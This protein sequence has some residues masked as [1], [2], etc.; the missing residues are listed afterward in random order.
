MKQFSNV[1][2]DLTL[3]LSK[4]ILKYENLLIMG[5]FNI[6]VKS[7]NLAFDYLD[8]FCIQFDLANYIKSETCFTKNRKSFIDL[9]FTNTPLPFQKSHLSETNLSNYHKLI[10]T[11][12]KTNFSSLEFKVLSY[13]N[14]NNL[15]SLIFQ[16]I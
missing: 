6:D 13:R 1:L 7:Q 11:F 10:K 8:E 4:I 15:P 5:D 2:V 12:F 3:S 14:C 9:F 16:S